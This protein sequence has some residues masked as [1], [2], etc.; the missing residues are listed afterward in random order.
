[1]RYFNFLILVTFCLLT[2]CSHN[3]VNRGPQQ[4][5]ETSNSDAEKNEQ[6]FINLLNFNGP[7]ETS[8][9]FRK[10]ID[11]QMGIFFIAQGYVTSFDQ[12]LNRLY[13]LRQKN[14][15]ASLDLIELER[16]HR[17]ILIIYEFYERNLHEVAYIY[18]RLLETASGS[19]SKEQISSRYILSSLKGIFDQ[20]YKRT[21]DQLAILSLAQELSTVED[22]FKFANPQAQTPDFLKKYLK[23]SGP[24]LNAARMQSLRL[25][26]TRQKVYLDHFLEKEWNEY[27]N[28]RTAEQQSEI[29]KSE[30]TP[31]SDDLNPDPGGKGHITG[32]M[33]A[34]GNWAIT[35]D[36]GP[37]PTHTSSIM[38]IYKDAGYPV[39][40]FWLTQ[41][42]LRYPEIVKQAEPY[43]FKRASH[44]Y[45]HANLPKLNSKQ[46]DYEINQAAIDFSKV[47]G[48]EPSF[49]RCPYGAC[50]MNSPI[51][52]MIAKRN[53]MHVFWNVDSLDWQDKNA[54]SVF[55][56]VKKQMLVLGK[57]IVLFHDIHPQSVE[58]TK[59][60]LAWLKKEKPD[61]KLYNMSEIF[62]I[63][64]NRDFPSP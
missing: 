37:H 48:K 10:Y 61:W 60:L 46:L 40:F 57:G 30:R 34:L 33:F 58:A 20:A 11:R 36:D 42:I 2:A 32:N 59:L 44:S 56:R 4:E 45:T 7:E 5:N 23:M 14:P 1:M 22:N 64:T 26:E 3:P 35:Y 53:M 17:Q 24:Q 43:G 55:D 41:N 39:T 52:Q 12:E 47:V 25:H 15:A 13:L 21:G 8:K 27:L 50:A 49:F 63:E 9:N 38:N 51:R 31:Q 18:K 62:K 6:V 29:K 19:L 16:I 54:Q 28:Q